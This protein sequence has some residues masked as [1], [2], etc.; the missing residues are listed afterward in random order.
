MKISDNVPDPDHMGITYRTK[1]NNSLVDAINDIWISG[2]LEKV[3][4]IS[5]KPDLQPEIDRL[6]RVVQ[7]QDAMIHEYEHPTLKVWW[8]VTKALIKRWYLWAE[9]KL[10]AR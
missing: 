7:E 1:G 10:S 2:V 6:I 3:T 4:G 5:A 9:N 8:K